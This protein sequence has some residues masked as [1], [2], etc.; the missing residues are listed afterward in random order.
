MIALDTNVVVRFLVRDDED[1]AQRARALVAAG[2]VLLT[3]TVVLETAWVLRA[4]Y[5]HPPEAV[6]D[7]LEGVL[8]LPTVEAPP[9]KPI[10]RALAWHRGGLDLADALHL[11]LSGEAE[12]FATFDRRLQARAGALGAEP[13]TIEPPAPPTADTT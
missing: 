1:Q 9:R 7:A 2:P 3:A 10:A 11:A 5:E 12:A 8:A 6:A 13:R 4:A